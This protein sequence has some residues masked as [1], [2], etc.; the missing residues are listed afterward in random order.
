[1]SSRKFGGLM[2]GVLLLMGA[3]SALADNILPPPWAGES[4]TTVQGWEFSDDNLNPLPDFGVNP[5]GLQPATV[6][7]GYPWLPESNGRQGVWP[8]SGSITFPIYN[9]PEPYPEK[10]IWIQVT[11][12]PQDVGNELHVGASAAGATEL[13]CAL[14]DDV[15][16]ADGWRH[17]T[18]E[19]ILEPNPQMEDVEVWGWVNVDEVVIHTRCIPEP[20]T[21][22]LIALGGLMMLRRRR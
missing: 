5:F 9:F 16:L 21:L 10:R 19:I 18:T 11:W 7:P 3:S 13:G 15:L 6:N 20:A 12:Q 17:T 22:G 8:L 14:I 4:R 2:V 1:M